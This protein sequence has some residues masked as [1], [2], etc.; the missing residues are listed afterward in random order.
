MISRGIRNTT[1]LHPVK[2]PIITLYDPW[3]YLSL[4]LSTVERVPTAPIQLAVTAL[5]EP[6]HQ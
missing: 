6:P 2:S 5:A 4:V 3:Y 1:V